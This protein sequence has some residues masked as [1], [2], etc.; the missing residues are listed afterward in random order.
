MRLNPT[1]GALKAARNRVSCKPQHSERRV[2]RCMLMQGNRPEDTSWDY[3][4]A[5]PNMTRSFREAWHS[6]APP[7]TRP[8]PREETRQ[9]AT[10]SPRFVC[11]VGRS[12]RVTV[13]IANPPRCCSHSWQAEC[14]GVPPVRR[15][16]CQ[17][18]SEF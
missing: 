11:H 4:S 12:C 8:S 7:H 15:Y 9:L 5:Y 2:L 17:G 13:S 1:Q 18:S 10:C 16:I 3:W 14:S 6:C